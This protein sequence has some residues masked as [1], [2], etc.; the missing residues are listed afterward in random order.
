MLKISQLKSFF[1][2]L[3]LF[4]KILALFIIVALS[5]IVFKKI[6]AEK[7][8]TNQYETAQAERGTLV[9]SVSASG[10]ISSGS[11]TDILTSASGVVSKVYVKNGEKVTKGQKIAEIALD[12][13][14]RARETIAYAAYIDAIN[15]EK[16]AQKNKVTA[17]IQMWKDRQAYL[18]A[19]DAQNDKN[20]VN[21]NPATN[22]A[23]TDNEVAIIDKTVEQTK[24][25]FEASETAFKNA[26]AQINKAKAQITSAWLNYLRSSG[27]IRAPVSGIISNL[28][29]SSG[30]TIAAVSS[31]TSN[32]SLN[33]VSTQKI[34]SIE[35][36]NAQYQAIVN[37]TEIDVTKVKPDQKATL[38]LDAFADKTFTGKVLS[39]DTNGKV[40]SGVT[41]YP[42]TILFDPTDTRIYPNMAVTAKIITDIKNDVILI[43]SSAV[44]T[45]NG[46]STV[47]VM[48]NGKVETVNVEI[49]GSNDTQTAVAEGIN[50]GDTV[51]ISV[52][53]AASGNNR[54]QNSSIF[55]AIGGNRNFGNMGRNIQVITR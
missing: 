8:Q 34:G 47:Q 49:I 45:I 4:L 42:T 37:L 13:D 11:S 54:S 30:M 23:Y 46:Q 53:S 36:P 52:L 20:T 41:T 26:D 35:N 48:K 22:K 2:G 1:K 3:P 32:S 50:E 25:A 6:G 28:T 18:D 43:P 24:K 27:T 19:Q 15:A 29:L 40:S 55:G 21:I 51:I 33:S 12:D 14:A 16:T 31:S 39:I 9:V 10:T 7:K 38:T 5:W 44:R 17:D